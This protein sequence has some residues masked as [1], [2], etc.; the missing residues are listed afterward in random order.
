M[1]KLPPIKRGVYMKLE[2]LFK[3]NLTC[4]KKNEKCF[5]CKK[6]GVCGKFIE[7]ENRRAGYDP[8]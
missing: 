2:D 3:L 7:Y 5:K 4:W 8:F 1:I 6:M